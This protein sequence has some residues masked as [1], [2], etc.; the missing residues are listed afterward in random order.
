MLFRQGIAYRITPFLLLTYPREWVDLYLYE[1]YFD[2]DP[3]I[4]MSRFSF[5]PVDWSSIDRKKPEKCS[6]FQASRRIWSRTP[7][8]DHSCARP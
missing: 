5:L 3:V 4:E 7:R 1:N 8:R 2:I 6:L